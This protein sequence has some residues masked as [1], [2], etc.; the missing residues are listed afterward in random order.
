M[1]ASPD[2]TGGPRALRE[3]SGIVQR[4]GRPNYVTL[5]ER[6]GMMQTAHRELPRPVLRG[7]NGQTGRPGVDRSVVDIPAVLVGLLPVE[8]ARLQPEHAAGNPGRHYFVRD[9]AG[10]LPMVAE[11]RLR[12]L[13]RRSAMR[14]RDRTQGRI[15]DRREV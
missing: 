4:G 2:Q 14:K 5:F 11:R 13:R 6:F 1:V 10:V 8:T 9:M 12:Q 7:R 3:R 15:A